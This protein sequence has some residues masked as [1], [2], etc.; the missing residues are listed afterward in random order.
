MAR[1][2]RFLVL[3]CCLAF[4][5]T[6][7]CSPQDSSSGYMDGNDLLEKCDSASSSVDRT[8]CLGYVAGVMDAAV[9]MLNSLRAA[10]STKV[11]AMYC[12]P[13]GGIQLGQA[14]RVILKWLKDHP[15]KQHLRGDLLIMMAMS[16]AFP[17]K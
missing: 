12:L 2:L 10:S 14:S 6:T 13:T 16:D 15:E 9:T 1:N 3:S 7:I 8:E 4:A 5:F 17:C 11:P